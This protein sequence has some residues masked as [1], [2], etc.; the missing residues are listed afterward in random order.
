MVRSFWS[1]SSG[2]LLDETAMVIST[3]GCKF[4]SL[5][6]L[7]SHK[8]DEQPSV[9]SVEETNQDST[10]NQDGADLH[11]TVL[12]AIVDDKRHLRLNQGLDG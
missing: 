2:K 5:W 11:I 9:D 10:H 6:V 3:E 1:S 12:M 7:M 8:G 4:A